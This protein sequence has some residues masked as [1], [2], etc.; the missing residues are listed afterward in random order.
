[1]SIFSLLRVHRRWD[2]DLVETH[3]PQINRVPKKLT[4][5]GLS[6]KTSLE[7]IGPDLYVAR[8]YTK[9][10]QKSEKY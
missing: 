1:M 6:N 9:T 2:K 10:V 8:F 4:N 7:K 3:G 5:Y